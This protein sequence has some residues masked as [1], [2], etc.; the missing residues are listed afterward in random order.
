M[1]H[2]FGSHSSSEHV[3]A[4][5]VAKIMVSSTHVHREVLQAQRAGHLV[6][7]RL[8]LATRL[9]VTLI[10]GTL[11]REPAA[12]WKEMRH[13]CRCSRVESRTWCCHPCRTDQCHTGFGSHSSVCTSRQRSCED[14]GVICTCAREVLQAQ[15][16]GHLVLASL[17][18]TARLLVTLIEGTLGREPVCE[19]E[20]DASQVQM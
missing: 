18:L 8:T 2:G 12:K 10:E 13:R 1:P 9:L 11:G 16:R 4:A 20:G 17:A 7:A 14:H 15:R 6:L 5:P 3:A 19:M